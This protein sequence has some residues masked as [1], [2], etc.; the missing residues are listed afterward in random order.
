[1][2]LY[3]EIFVGFKRSSTPTS[4]CHIWI[5]ISHILHNFSSLSLALINRS[6][7]PYPAACRSRHGQ[8]ICKSPLHFYLTSIHAQHDIFHHI[9]SVTKTYHFQVSSTSH[10]CCVKWHVFTCPD[11]PVTVNHALLKRNS[12]NSWK[13]GPS[14]WGNYYDWHILSHFL[15]SFSTVGLILLFSQY[16][17]NVDVPMVSYKKKKWMVFQYPLFKLFSVSC[18]NFQV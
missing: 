2:L 9:W 8:L 6:V 4:W 11:L 16:L 17:S 12:T 7:S 1:M 15:F 18:Q 10:A 5:V 3:R 13:Q 14:L